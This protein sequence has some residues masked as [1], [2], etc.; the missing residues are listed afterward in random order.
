[1]RQKWPTKP[2]ASSNL[3]PPWVLMTKSSQSSLED[4][5]VPA[6]FKCLFPFYS[7][8]LWEIKLCCSSCS[9][10]ICAVNYDFLSQ[11]VLFLFHVLQSLTTWNGKGILSVWGIISLIYDWILVKLDIWLKCSFAPESFRGVLISALH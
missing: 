5:A 8:N 11:L 9:L 7:R 1:M 2:T 3:W 10:D 4:G 6:F